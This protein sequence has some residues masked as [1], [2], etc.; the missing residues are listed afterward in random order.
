MQKRSPLRFPFVLIVLLVAAVLWPTANTQAAPAQAPATA[1]PTGFQYFS[2]TGH[3]IG[4]DVKR[5]FDANGGLDVF[6][7]PLTELFVENGTYV[8]YFERARFE[9]YPDKPVGQRVLLSRLGA[10]LTASRANEP[11][12]QWLTGSSDPNRDFYP[13]SGHTLGGAFRSYWHNRGGLAVFG[14][15]ISEEFEEWN[16]QDGNIYTVQYFERARFEFHPERLGTPYEVQLGHVGRKILESN[17]IAVAATPAVQPITLLGR[18]TTGFATS[19]DERRLNI[20]V[21]T[22]MFNG[23]VVAPGEEHSFL[24][25][26]DFSEESGFVDGYAIVNGRMEKVIGGGLCQVS[27][28]LFRA[29]ANAGMHITSRTGHSHVVYFYENILGFDAT[30]F[31]PY[32]DFK[33][34]NDTAHPVYISTGSNFDAATVTFELWGISDGRTVSYEGPRI[35]NEKRPGTPVWQYDATLARGQV[36]QLVHGRGGMDVN[37]IRTVKMPDGSTKHYDNWFTRYTPWDD[38][39]LYGP[40]VTPPAG[41]KVLGPRTN[42]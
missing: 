37:Y 35:R 26:G 3:N 18:S 33:W 39:Y 22:E 34:R 23:V 12:F 25:G 40:G 42:Y 8:Q 7:L 2:E 6:G 41:V 17:P 28:T 10:Q 5:F 16:E 32:L 4:L 21:A 15:P 1:A 36:V 11:Q 27:T 31:S 20:A 13:Q 9:Y 19:A 30:V 29:A 14:Y 38:F 24:A